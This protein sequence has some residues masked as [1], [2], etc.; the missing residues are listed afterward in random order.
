MIEF[1][2]K[3]FGID[4]DKPIGY[5]ISACLIVGAI[6]MCFRLTTLFL[7]WVVR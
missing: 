1:F 3:N 4:I 7:E 6:R 5:L 2:K